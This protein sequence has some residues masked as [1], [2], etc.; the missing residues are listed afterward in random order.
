MRQPSF[1]R[2]TPRELGIGSWDTVQTIKRDTPIIAALALFLE[3][4]VSA[5]PV[6]D[7]DGRLVDIYAKFDVINLAT[8][9]AYN[10]LDVPVAEALKK[11]SNVS[12]RMVV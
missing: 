12:D 9:G 8:E 11:R 5:L 6:V 10:H 4:R 7:D 2:R 1:M 3:K